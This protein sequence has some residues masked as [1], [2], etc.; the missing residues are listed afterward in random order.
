LQILDIYWYSGVGSIRN[1]DFLK[2]EIDFV[3]MFGS[4]L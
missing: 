2:F 4:E 3:F 1:W